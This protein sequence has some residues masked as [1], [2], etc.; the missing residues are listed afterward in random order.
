MG[1]GLNL[2]ND[3]AVEAFQDFLNGDRILSISVLC[4]LEE[5]KSFSID[6]G[7]NSRENFCDQGLLRPEMVVHRR[8]IHF[9]LSG[10]LAERNIAE[11]VIGEQGLGRVEDP[12][13]RFLFVC[14]SRRHVVST[15]R[16]RTHVSNSCLKM[17]RKKR[18]RS[19]NR[20]W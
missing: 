6:R 16:I 3:G 15:C 11:P 12:E 17:A 20:P 5:A 10:D 2:A 8:G 4:Q 9:R 13:P 14:V 1:G 19:W 7:D 18:N